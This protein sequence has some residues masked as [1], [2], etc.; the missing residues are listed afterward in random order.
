M[1]LT[2]KYHVSKHGFQALDHAGLQILT[3]TLIMK[4][5]L[6]VQKLLDQNIVSTL[7]SLIFLKPLDHAAGDCNAQLVTNLS[8]SCICE[9]PL[10]FWLQTLSCL[11]QCVPDEQSDT[12][13]GLDMLN[14]CRLLELLSMVHSNDYEEG[15]MP[16]NTWTQSRQSLANEKA[17]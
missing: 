14:M 15:W 1:I 7:I 16:S 11:R 12:G 4:V 2:M 10:G 17:D 9:K 13:T 5:H 6:K 8:Y 3:K